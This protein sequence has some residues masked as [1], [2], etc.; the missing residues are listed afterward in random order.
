MWDW[1]GWAEPGLLKWSLLLFS[2]SNDLLSQKAVWIWQGLFNLIPLDM[3][4][5][6]ARYDLSFWK[7]ALFE[8]VTQFD[9]LWKISVLHILLLFLCD[10]CSNGVQLP[11]NKTLSSFNNKHLRLSGGEVCTGPLVMRL[12]TLDTQPVLLWPHLPPE[13]WPRARAENNSRERRW[14][15]IR[16]E[17][18]SLPFVQSCLTKVNTTSFLS[19][20][21]FLAKTLL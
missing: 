11:P 16:T 5:E 3:K 15:E 9:F 13:T 19:L 1:E 18:G 6:R 7:Q 4:I 10:S 17:R 8:Y 14:P 12:T 21:T 2:L 20:F